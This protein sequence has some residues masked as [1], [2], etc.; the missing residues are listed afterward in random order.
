MKE[1]IIPLINTG[2]LFRYLI[3][4][5]V[6]LYLMYLANK[7]SKSKYFD[8]FLRKLDTMLDENENKTWSSKRFNLT[9]TVISSNF[10]LWFMYGFLCFIKL[11]IVNIPWEVTLAYGTANGIAVF[12]K[13]WQ[14][15]IEMKK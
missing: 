2:L 10:A 4:I 11:D 13:V 3:V 7:F 14:K 6:I 1:E 15:F 12:G 8:P 5:I 9:L